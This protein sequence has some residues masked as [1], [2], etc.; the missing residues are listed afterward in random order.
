MCTQKDKR[1]H[2][3]IAFLVVFGR[4][5]PFLAV[6]EEKKCCKSRHLPV[7]HGTLQG[8]L[9]TM[10]KECRNMLKM[11]IFGDFGL[12]LA[13]FGRFLPFL[14]KKYVENHVIYLSFMAHYWGN[15][16]LCKESA[17]MCTKWPFLVIFAIFGR[18]WPFLA[19]F[20]KKNV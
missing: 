16:S 9:S 11:A 5:W 6:F 8:Q 14:T 17:E 1:K 7:F 15:L 13:F 19:V 10:Q 4:F 2:K 18:F 20:E 12:F 3:K